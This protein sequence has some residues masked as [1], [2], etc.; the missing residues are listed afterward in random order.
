MTRRGFP[1]GTRR[2]PAARLVQ[3]RPRQGPE[4]AKVSAGE[5][6]MFTNSVS[7]SGE[8]VAPANSSSVAALN[9]NAKVSPFSLIPTSH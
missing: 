9:A 5:P 8:N 2:G 4:I 1:P 7:P 3:P 6:W